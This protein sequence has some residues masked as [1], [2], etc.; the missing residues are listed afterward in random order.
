M[1]P[2]KQMYDYAKEQYEWTSHNDVY[3][4]KRIY[5]DMADEFWLDISFWVDWDRDWGDD[6]IYC[7][8]YMDFIWSIVFNWACTRYSNE[9]EYKQAVDY[10]FYLQEEW[11]WIRDKI[12][13]L[14]QK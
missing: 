5:N 3:D 13:N 1:K 12:L 6:E 4:L 8:I 14:G 9:D 10:L 2:T 11:E 7:Y